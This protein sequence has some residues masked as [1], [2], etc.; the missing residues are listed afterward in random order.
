MTSSSV[1]PFLRSCFDLR[2]VVFESMSSLFYLVCLCMRTLDCTRM[3]VCDCTCVYGCVWVWVSVYMYACVCMCVCVCAHVCICVCVCLCM[4]VC[5]FVCVCVCTCVYVYVCVCVWLRTYVCMCVDECVCVC[6]VLKAF[7]YGLVFFV[8]SYNNLRGL[9]NTKSI[10]IKEQS[11]YY[12]IH[13]SCVGGCL[14]RV[15][16]FPKGISPKENVIAWLEFEFVYYGV[17]VRHF[18]HNA[19]SLCVS[20][21][22]C[23]C[24][25]VVCIYRMS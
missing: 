8:Q 25:R 11:W 19:I 16:I 21:Y 7:G 15:H 24:I 17:A 9:F 5:A 1:Q 4:C 18:T 23:D 10:L 3:C 22:S 6:K 13:N 12:L 20:Q 14:G 2:W